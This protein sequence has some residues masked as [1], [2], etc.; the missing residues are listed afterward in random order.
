MGAASTRPTGIGPRGLRRP[1]GPE[2]SLMPL[3]YVRLR[4]RALATV[5]FGLVWVAISV[6]I[7][8][9]WIESLAASITLP[10][11]ILVVAGIALVPGYL[12]ANLLA[13]VLLDRPRPLPDEKKL[14][15]PR[16]TI[17]VAA[18][19]EEA[20]IAETLSYASAQDYPGGLDILVIDDGSTDRTAA[21]A[22]AAA[23]RDR[24][25]RVIEA[26]H[27][28]KAAAL[29]RGLG[30]VATELVATIDADTLLMPQSLR[31]A[32][33]RLLVSP[34]DTVAV[35]GAILVRNSRQNLLT[36]LQEWDYF[37]GIATIKR[38][39]ALMQATLVAQG[40]F[41]LYS[42]A[43]LREAGGWKDRLGEDIVL[44]WALLANGGRTTYE[45]TAVAFTR[46]PTKLR[47]FGRQRRRW[48]RGMIEGLRE[49]GPDLVGSKRYLAH[50]V[51]VDYLFPFVDAAFSLVFIPGIVLALFGN[52]AI[53]GPMTVAV[54]PL[55]LLLAGV[56]LERQRRVFR[57]V[58][59]VERR[60]VLGFAAYVFIY[61]LI[62][63]P[64]SLAGYVQELGRRE[65]RW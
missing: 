23:F 38:Q 14:T 24:R 31:R 12:N 55:N 54:L 5:L 42:L 41:S 62:S 57:A 13:S 35:A 27:A 48:A 40:A 15:F 45:A 26:P 4:T 20:S 18:F 6:W 22:S 53:V 19:N 47:W 7:A 33:A 10:G 65:A 46:A 21:V 3:P 36:R 11:A 58:G 34:P 28:G 56:M 61:Q 39:Q 37:L 1:R 9:P 59:L 29:N 30:E 64:V 32:V 44:T 50:G 51:A 16:V 52:Y 17:L 8:V 60:N 25:I 49:Y 63:S 43:A 2:E